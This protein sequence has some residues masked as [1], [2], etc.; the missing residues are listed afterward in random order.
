MPFEGAGRDD[1]R[2]GTMAIPRSKAEHK[3]S[4]EKNAKI[5]N[6]GIADISQKKKNHVDGSK[7]QNIKQKKTKSTCQTNSEDLSSDNDIVVCVHGTTKNKTETK[8]QERKESDFKKKGR[9]KRDSRD[10]EVCSSGRHKEQLTFKGKKIKRR[11]NISIR[12]YE[13]KDIESQEKHTLKKKN[14]GQPIKGKSVPDIESLT[15]ESGEGPPWKLEVHQRRSNVE[16]REQCEKKGH[17]KASRKAARSRSRGCR[18]THIRK[19]V[20][21]YSKANPVNSD[22]SSCSDSQVKNWNPRG[23]GQENKTKAP[24]NKSKVRE[25]RRHLLEDDEVLYRKKLLPTIVETQLS[26]ERR[27]CQESHKTSSESEEAANIKQESQY[28]ESGSETEETIKGKKKR[29]VPRKAVSNFSNELSDDD[30]GSDNHIGSTMEEVSSEGQQE[31]P[32]EGSSS[33][34]D[35]DCQQNKHSSEE[36]ENETSSLAEI[37]SNKKKRPVRSKTLKTGSS[38][39]HQGSHQA[40]DNVNVSGKM[41]EAENTFSAQQTKHRRQSCSKPEMLKENTRLDVQKSQE[42]CFSGIKNRANVVA[43]FTKRYGQLTSQSQTLLNLKGKHNNANASSKC[44][45]PRAAETDS[46]LEKTQSHHSKQ[47][48]TSNNQVVS[49]SKESRESRSSFSTVSSSFSHNKNLSAERKKVGKT[50]GKVS[51]TSHQALG[52]R[53]EE[54][55]EENTIGEEDTEKDLLVKQ[56]RPLCTLS[57]FRK[58]TRWLSH[59]S[60]KK[61]TLKDRFLSVARAVG[62]SGWLFKK[63]GKM[64]RSSKS[65]GFRRRMAIRIVSTAGLVKRCNKTSC[66]STVEQMRKDLSN[67]SSSLLK[68][69]QAADEDTQVTEK[70]EE[71]GISPSNFPRNEANCL[72]QRSSTRLPQEDKNIPDAKFAVVFPRVHQLLKSKNASLGTSDNCKSLKQLCHQS[73]RKAGMS[74]QPSGKFQH[75]LMKPDGQRNSQGHACSSWPDASPPEGDGSQD[76]VPSNMEKEEVGS[77]TDF[78]QRTASEAVNQV[79]WTQEQPLRCDPMAWLNSETLLPWLTVENLSKWTI[80]T[81][82]NV[83]KSPRSTVSRER[84]ETEDGAEDI[85][86]IDLAQK[87]YKYEDCYL[88]LEK[89]EDLSR[90]EEVCESSILLCLKRRF[91]LNL[92]Y[93]YIGQILVCI[94]PFRPLNQYSEDVMIQHQKGML[95]R[96][97]PHIFA[98]TEMAYT[99]SQSSAREQCIIISGHSGSGKTETAK[100]IIRYLSRLYQPQEICGKKQSCDVLPILESFGN[101]RTILNDNS[102][103]FGKFLNVHLRKGLMVG[104]SVSQYLLEKSRVVFQSCGERSFHVFYELLAGL[105]IG[106]KEELY[107]QE[108]ETYFYLNQASE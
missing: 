1:I 20:K 68:C 81:E 51:L 16:S 98:I 79:H 71:G 6:Q 63:L 18:K 40:D 83:A 47:N 43:L 24:K 76:P 19:S 15:I 107:L 34:E 97:S 65:F 64:K 31:N 22:D 32:S 75:E 11:H 82:Q 73:R 104:L 90:L 95:F 61:T 77:M 35:S 5:E 57:A 28:E 48:A 58:V 53:E 74:V 38:K 10:K 100:A 25:G 86:E 94:N 8:I 21:I 46:D 78:I 3:T 103:R 55:I 45:L 4:R 105:P 12:S 89:V 80:Y 49:R 84:W 17:C 13:P 39:I 99:F 30:S 2:L 26:K 93:T 52:T 59:K 92:I 7:M 91:H 72:P 50:I 96:S 36:D 56:T 14:K 44:S 37:K 88:E 69:S 54:E 29:S 33:K 108:A 42:D 67:K 70:L 9:G 60:L 87:Q 85:L 62:I 27:V 41:A 66:D 102:S 101:A 23:G 106:Q